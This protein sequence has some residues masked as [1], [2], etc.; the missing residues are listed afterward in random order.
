MIAKG[1]NKATTFKMEK[2]NKEEKATKILTC[3]I[4]DQSL[5]ILE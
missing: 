1:K 5:V 2:K 4:E 3:N